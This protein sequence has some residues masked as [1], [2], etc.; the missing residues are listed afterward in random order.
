MGKKSWALAVAA[1]VA[2][3]E[4]VV[5]S[6]LSAASRERRRLR[7]RPSLSLLVG[8]FRLSKGAFSCFFAAV[9]STEG[10]RRKFSLPWVTEEL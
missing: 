3:A 5:L 2:A 6:R 7:R 4:A 9:L 1:A 8:L 10:P